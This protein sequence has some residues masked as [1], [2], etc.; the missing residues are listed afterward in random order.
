LFTDDHFAA[1]QAFFESEEGAGVLAV[2][3]DNGEDGNVLV[4]DGIE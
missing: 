3:A 4:G 1:R 2:G